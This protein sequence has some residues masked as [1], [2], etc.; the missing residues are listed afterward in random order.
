M[1]FDPRIL[2][3]SNV[4]RLSRMVKDFDRSIVGIRWHVCILRFSVYRRTMTTKRRARGLLNEDSFPQL[5]YRPYPHKA[6]DPHQ[7]QITNIPPKSHS[8][9][10]RNTPT[11]TASFIPSPSGLSAKS[12][13]PALPAN[14]KLQPTMPT[15]RGSSWYLRASLK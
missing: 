12:H 11:S 5:I 8:Q 1:C 13:Q 10:R 15:S 4:V 6:V 14:R 7:T 9:M 3:S 2:D